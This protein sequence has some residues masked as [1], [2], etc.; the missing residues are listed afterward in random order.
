M[1][2]YCFTLECLSDTELGSGLGLETVNSIVSRDHLDRPVLRGS[3]LKGILRH[4]LQEVLTDLPNAEKLIDA[5]LGRPGK[6]GDDG[7][8]G[9]LRL[10]DAVWKSSPDAEIPVRTITRT[11]LDEKGTALSGSLRSTEALAAGTLFRGTATLSGHEDEVLT[12]TL[13]LGLLCI[14]SI[15]GGRSRG[16]GLCKVTLENAAA[17][18]TPGDLL[19]ALASELSNWTPG[20]KPMIQLPDRVSETEDM[21]WLQLRFDAEDPVCCPE[22][23]GVTESNFIQSGI[24]IPASAVWGGLLTK[25]SEKDV[26]LA[27]HTLMNPKA[28][29]WPLLPTSGEYGLPSRIPQSHRI[30]KLP[31]GPNG[32]YTYKDAAIQSY[33]WRDVPRNA[34]LKGTDGILLREGDSVKLWRSG[35]MPRVLSSHAVHYPKPTL[36]TMEAIAP[37][38]FAGLVHVPGAFAESLEA[39]LQNNN[40]VVFGKSR[41]IR[42]GGR[43]T[44]QRVQPSDLFTG[45][46]TRVWILQSPAA[47]PDDWQLLGARSESQ[48]E[49]LTRD[50]GWG[51]LSPLDRNASDQIQ[52]QTLAAC[53]IRFGWNRVGL[54]KGTGLGGQRCARRVFLP[55]SVFVLEKEEA[56]LEAALVRGLGI[57]GR[58]G[59][60]GRSQGFGALLP[61]PGIANELY[62]P[63]TA[64]SGEMKPSDQ[65]TRLALTF[66]NK[67]GRESGP[68]PSQIAAVAQRIEPGNAG[69]ATEYLHKQRTERP[70]RIWAKWEGVHAILIDEINENPDQAKRALRIWQDLAINS[71]KEEA[72]A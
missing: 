1:K 14:S 65:A 28:R 23:P 4:T 2:N 51:A 61:H 6:E 47:I 58:N 53:G 17:Q 62:Q 57:P 52:V 39:V 38:S 34:P 70:K 30:S 22:R 33:H 63:V 37:V 5:L 72:N 43:L 67:A 12:K 71:R 20:I 45:W 56:D 31:T 69:V 59:P 11:A 40:R 42:G 49:R 46:D 48:L 54:G 27:I 29:V 35:E 60:D 16:S 19:L 21:V 66:F 44:V 15:G 64:L 41:S 24:D 25:V 8:E 26:E 68:S 7:Q 18:V 9:L 10:P 50:S 13:Q 3:H 55:G 36:F 32:Q